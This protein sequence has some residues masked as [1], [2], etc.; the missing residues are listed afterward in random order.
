MRDLFQLWRDSGGGACRRGRRFRYL[1]GQAFGKVIA[2][3]PASGDIRWSVKTR[4]PMSASVLATAGGLIFTGDAEGN[5]VA[6][7]DRT[8]N[9]LWSFQT[10]SG[11]RSGPIA[12][13]LDGV[14]YIAVASGLGG[15]VGGYT[16]RAPLLSRRRHA[17]RV[18]AV[19][20][21]A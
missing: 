15:A 4:S 1:P 21:D 20:A 10:G 2:I 7:D 16:A 17:V 5:L 12:F 18:P 3:D 9:L 14:E 19:Q 6:Y 11:I 13:E 8:G